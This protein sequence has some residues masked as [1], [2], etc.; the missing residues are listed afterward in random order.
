MHAKVIDLNEIE[1]IPVEHQLYGCVCES[2]GT[3]K[4][5]ELGELFIEKEV[6]KQVSMPPGQGRARA[7]MEITD[8]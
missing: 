4:V 7:Q 5:D 6:L 3:V 1:D 2:V 8:Y